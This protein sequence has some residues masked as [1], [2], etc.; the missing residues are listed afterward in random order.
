MARFG[1]FDQYLQDDGNPLVSGK[2]YFFETGTTT[3]KTTY[4][5]INN[6]IPNTHPV[7]LTASGRQPN[8]F[9]DGVAKAILA[10]SS[11]V[12]IAVLDP[13]GETTTDFGDEWVPT[14]IYTA[15]DVVI[16]SDGIFYRSLVNGN[17][18]NNPINTSGS[19]ALLYSVEWNAGITYAVGALVTL[20]NFQYQSLQSANLNQS[21]STQTA[22]WV[23]L[24]FAWTATAVYATGQNAVGTDGI[25]YTSL[26]DSNTGNVPASSATYW[27]GTSAA[28]AASATASANSATA[29]AASETAAATS[30]TNAAT[31]ATNSANSATASA[32][33]ATASASSATASANSATASSGSETA[34]ANSATAAAGSATAA[35][36]KFDEF[37]AIYLGEKSSDPTVDN[38][39]GALVEGALYFNTVSDAMKVYDGSAWVS[40]APVATSVTVSQISDYTGTATELNYTDGVTSPIQDQIDLKAPLSSPTFV[41]PALG[42]PASGVATNLTGTASSLTAGNVIT[43]ANL[44]GVVTSVGNATAIANKA[45]AVAKLADGTDGELI[46]W[47]A[48]GVAAT[49]AAGTSAQVLTSNGAGA[50][51]TFQDAAGGGSLVFLS[52]TTLTT[53]VSQVDI[54]LPSGYDQYILEINNLRPTSNSNI[55]MRTSTDGGSTFNSGG[56][57]YDYVSRGYNSS[58]TGTTKSSSSTTAMFLFP[59]NIGSSYA[60]GSLSISI[61]APADAQRTLFDFRGGYQDS[62]SESVAVYGAASRKSATDVDAVRFFGTTMDRGY[63]ALYGVKRS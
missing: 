16:G 55:S 59:T 60:G 57:D 33:S 18:N 40:I 28:A 43:N 36:N 3:A 50:A 12:Q 9:F 10:T 63:F 53:G 34:A 26:Q 23:P 15:K 58:G 35:S 19:W 51:P 61:R 24:N 27:V 29:S 13:V 7:I 4:S 47:D 21:P 2:L 11:D 31:S 5:D 41:T 45:I 44:T 62:N 37:D 17:Q 1:D 54:T 20:D 14:K 22:Y 46:T 39:G 48:S 49:V 25:L 32:S 42:T 56:A 52:A 6:S 8:V 30:E 38:Q